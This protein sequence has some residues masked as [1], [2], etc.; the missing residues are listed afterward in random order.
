MPLNTEDKTANS[1]A[2]FSNSYT[3]SVKQ[4]ETKE[5]DL[6]FD[7]NGCKEDILYGKRK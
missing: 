2:P 7:E 1:Q 3:F 6:V 5:F 4:I